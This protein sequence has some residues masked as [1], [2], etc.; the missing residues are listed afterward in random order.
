MQDWRTDRETA[1]RAV[2]LGTPQ[3]TNEQTCDPARSRRQ[4]AKLLSGFEQFIS[5]TTFSIFYASH[6]PRPAAAFRRSAGMQCLTQ[7]ESDLLA[8]P[9][10]SAISRSILRCLSGSAQR[11]SAG[12]CEAAMRR[13]GPSPLLGVETISGVASATR[14][15]HCNGRSEV[16]MSSLA[17]S[18][19]AVIVIAQVGD[20]G[21]S[22]PPNGISRR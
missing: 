1:K 13:R 6:L 7:R 18:A 19:C 8:Q 17:G 16:G 3:M 5:S 22:H 2:T 21:P 4:K 15:I 9:I 10:R 20:D 11:S 12:E 14:F